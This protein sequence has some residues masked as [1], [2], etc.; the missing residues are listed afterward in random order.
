MKFSDV[1]YFG[2]LLTKW[3]SLLSCVWYICLVLSLPKA[4][5]SWRKRRK[6]F[7]ELE[8]EDDGNEIE[9]FRYNKT[10]V[11]PYTRLVKTQPRQTQHAGKR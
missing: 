10:I 7:Q 3:Q 9:Y 5:K 6:S 4:Q 2:A 8:A 11:I 1:I